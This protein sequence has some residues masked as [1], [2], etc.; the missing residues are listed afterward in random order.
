MAMLQFNSNADNARRDFYTI[1]GDSVIEPD[2][3]IEFELS[4]PAGVSLI[5]NRRTAVVTIINDDCESTFSNSN[6]DICG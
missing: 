6:I 2:E 3:T 5:P 4:G 1:I